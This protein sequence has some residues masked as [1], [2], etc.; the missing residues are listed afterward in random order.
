MTL[1]DL[2][3]KLPAG[4]Q[5]AVKEQLKTSLNLPMEA[6]QRFVAYYQGGD[7]RKARAE[8]VMNMTGPELDTAMAE[9]NA[10]MKA[11]GMRVST[12]K[13]KAK[14]FCDFMVQGLM[15]LLTAWLQSQME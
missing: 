9:T 2:I 14:A 10:R 5:D 12:E 4:M 13:A 15:G 11:A 6:A 7:L 1:K 8:L 3:D